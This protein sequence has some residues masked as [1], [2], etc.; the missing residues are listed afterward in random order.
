MQLFG[1]SEEELRALFITY[2]NQVED[3]VLDMTVDLAHD[4]LFL[5]VHFPIFFVIQAF[6]ICIVVRRFAVKIP[7]WHSFLVA[8]AM[9]FLGRTLTAFFTNRRPP[10]LDQPLYLPIFFAIWFL[11]NCSPFD[12]VFRILNTFPFLFLFQILYALLGVRETC[13][14]VDIGLRAFP[15]GGTGAVL[16]SAV[17]AST[18]SFVWLFF[19]D[20]VR[21]FSNRAVLRNLVTGIAYWGLT[22]YPEYVE[23]YFE[24]TK[25]NV[26]IYAL[27]GYLGVLLL[28][29][30]FFGL[31]GRKGFD[32][33]LLTYVGML[34]RYAGNK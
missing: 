5:T 18:E 19:W 31:R 7:W 21:E 4:Y 8:A 24:A 34:F 6:W 32:V 20:E 3:F 29:I 26:K 22:Q 25:E 15:L 9:S 27:L 12:L 28:D 16:L 1:L 23:D 30:L 17:L 2:Y 10:L 13:H 33:T 11:I 14:G